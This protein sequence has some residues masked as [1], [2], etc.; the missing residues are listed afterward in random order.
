M[1]VTSVT[2]PKNINGRIVDY[3]MFF[4]LQGLK[5]S[6]TVISIKSIKILKIRCYVGQVYA[7]LDS[8]AE[9]NVFASNNSSN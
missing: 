9:V 5:Y 1:H 3:Y 8:S 2:K 4:A 6:E 7:I